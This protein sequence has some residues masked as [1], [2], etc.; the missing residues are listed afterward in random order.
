MK[1]ERD[2]IIEIE[3]QLKEWK[4]SWKNTWN[5][6]LDRLIET[7]QDFYNMEEQSFKSP[8]ITK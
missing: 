4:I 2:L 1:T 7:I 8:Q 6:R 5:E 3:R